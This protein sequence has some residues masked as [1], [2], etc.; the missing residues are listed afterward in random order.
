MHIFDNDLELKEIKKNYL[1]AEVADNWSHRGNLNGGF[2]LSLAAKAA[3]CF[4]EKTGSMLI[5]ANYLDRTQP[6]I[7]DVQIEELSKSGNFDRF[8]VSLIQNDKKVLRTFCTLSKKTGNT[9]DLASNQDYHPSALEKDCIEMSRPGVTTMYD[10]LNVRIDPAT[11]S[12]MQ[13]ELKKP[14]NV[15]GWC[16]FREPRDFDLFAANM[17]VDCFPPAIFSSLGASAW[18][19]TLEMSVYI[20]HNPKVD[21]LWSDFRT[22]YITD[23]IL[24]EDGIV[25]DSDGNIVAISRQTA[26]YRSK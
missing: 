9:E 3:S 17:A 1:R 23:G 12:W 4:S 24:Q 10:S 13:G 16:R 20:T 26:V 8:E 2:L 19:P 7:I 11:A 14:S 6:G 22:N 5:T 21:V 15:R 25:T 18:V